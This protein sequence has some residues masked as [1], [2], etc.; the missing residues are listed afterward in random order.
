MKR[1]ILL[2]E[3][4]G[5][6]FIIMLGSLLHFTYEISGDNA[7]VGVFSA[8]NESV[9]E[10]LK[11]AFWPAMLFALIEFVPLKRFAQNFVL[12]KNVSVYVMVTVI[13]A[14]FYSYT[15]ITGENL[16]AVDIGSFLAAVV[17]GQLVSYK[18]L[19][20]RTLSVKAQW[21]ALFFVILLAVL[22]VVFTFVP[23][24]LSIFEDPITG[25]YGIC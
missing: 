5:I 3:I 21:I 6:V 25:N 7:L 18:L 12:A 4:V 1:K 9:W 19:T 17:I 23:P 15:A 10:H 20:Y 16:L 24:H 11:L 14:I 8:V 13:P 2:Y 22:F